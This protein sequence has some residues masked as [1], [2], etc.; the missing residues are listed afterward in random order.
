MILILKLS[1]IYHSIMVLLSSFQKFIIAQ[2]GDVVCWKL[3]IPDKMDKCVR[4]V[5]FKILLNAFFMPFGE[6]LFYAF[7]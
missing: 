5:V 6:W 7:W 1:Y 4:T 3:I 2:G